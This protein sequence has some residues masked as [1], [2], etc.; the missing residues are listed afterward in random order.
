M[1][2][3]HLVLKVGTCRTFRSF[4]HPVTTASFSQQKKLHI[5]ETLGKAPVK[6]KFFIIE[7]PEKVF[8]GSIGQM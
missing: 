5:T 3:E 2:V 1:D 8:L 4:K 6:G 7:V